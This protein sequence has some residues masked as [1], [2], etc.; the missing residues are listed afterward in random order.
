MLPQHPFRIDRCRLRRELTLLF[1]KPAGRPG[2]PALEQAA[3]PPDKSMDG[4][5]VGNLVGDHH[6]EPPQEVPRLDASWLNH[7]GPTL[8]GSVVEGL[9]Q[10]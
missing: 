10:Q 7:C 6:A 2:H 1:R 5:G 9:R 4:K 8:Y 3:I